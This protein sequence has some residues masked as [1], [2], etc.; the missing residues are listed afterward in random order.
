MTPIFADLNFKICVLLLKSA[1]N[2]FLA[3]LCVFVPWWY[4]FALNATQFT[5]ATCRSRR[6]EETSPA[7]A[8]GMG[9]EEERGRD[10]AEAGGRVVDWRARASHR[11]HFF[12]IDGP[13]QTQRSSSPFARS[14]LS[15]ETAFSFLGSS[16]SD[17]S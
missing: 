5:S 8:T 1:E 4:I 14:F 12:A 17:F 6:N 2:C 13:L 9:V 16:R 3:I 7:K 15:R 11:I 10:D